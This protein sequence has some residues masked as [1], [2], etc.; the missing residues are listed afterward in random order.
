[1]LLALDQSIR[2]TGYGVFQGNELIKHGH[3]SIPSNLPLGTRLKHFL[4]NLNT[5]SSLFQIDK[6]AFEDIQLQRG[7]V[8]T[9]KKLCYTQ[10]MIIFWCEKYNIPYVI[11]SPSHWRS[12]IKQKY[13]QSFGRSRQEQKQAALNFIQEYYHLEV[14]EDEADAI[15]IGLAAI[16]EEQ[17]NESAF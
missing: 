15:C 4:I 2:I 3:W 16:Q 7:N 1:M 12:I 17:Q 14:T 11:L 5:L 6:V 13:K 10:A 8:E 9:Y